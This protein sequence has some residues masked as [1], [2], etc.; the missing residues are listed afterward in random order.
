M[1]I[2]KTDV[3]TMKQVVIFMYTARC[4]LNENNGRHEQCDEQSVAR[5][6]LSSLLPSRRRWSLRHQGSEGSHRSM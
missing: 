5:R 1:V 2:N 4:E 6:S 3:E